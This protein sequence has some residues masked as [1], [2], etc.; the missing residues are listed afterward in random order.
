MPPVRLGLSSVPVS[1]SPF[2]IET[3]RLTEGGC[4]LQQC[5]NLKLHCLLARALTGGKGETS[6]VIV[7]LVSNA[8]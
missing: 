3:K 1:H 4:Y 7:L 5:P 2:A 8:C 6:F